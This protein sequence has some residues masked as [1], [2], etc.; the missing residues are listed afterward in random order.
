MLVAVDFVHVWRLSRHRK[1]ERRRGQRFAYH[2]ELTRLCRKRW[3]RMELLQVLDDRE[4]QKANGALRVS[5]Q[6]LLDPSVA[7]KGGLWEPSRL[8]S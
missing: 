8:V 1:P 6:Q 5:K 3:R 4:N 7:L 2:L